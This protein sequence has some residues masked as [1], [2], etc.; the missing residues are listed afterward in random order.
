M[1][2]PGDGDGGGEGVPV[3]GERRCTYI[4]VNDAWRR[5][6]SIALGLQ[7]H[8]H[9]LSLLLMMMRLALCLCLFGRGGLV[10]LF[11]LLRGTYRV[12]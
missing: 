8:G 2:A 9:C 4:Q 3:T 1:P 6:G 10:V 12:V 7:R 5:D 11:E